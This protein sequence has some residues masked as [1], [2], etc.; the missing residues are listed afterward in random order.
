MEPSKNVSRF[1]SLKE[2]Y[3][4]YLSEHKSSMTRAFHFFGTFLVLLLLLYGVIL[5]SW[6]A[7]ALMPVAG[8]GFAWFSHAFIEKNKP[9]TF[10]YPLWS[11]ASDF[12]MFWEMLTGKIK[13]KG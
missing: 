8:Y 10:T 3:P 5:G 11:L 9:A 13:H 4:Y 12:V 6:K 2:F 1:S 7:L